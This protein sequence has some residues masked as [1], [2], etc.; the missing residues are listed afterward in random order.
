MKKIIPKSGTGWTEIPGDTQ[1]I[2]AHYENGESRR[3]DII[4]FLV[5]RDKEDIIEI[6]CLT[7]KEHGTD[8][9]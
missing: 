4:D 5:L 7:G 3:M 9:L 6:V 1:I 8:L 2:I